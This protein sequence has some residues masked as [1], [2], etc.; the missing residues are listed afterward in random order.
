MKTQPFRFL[1]LPAELRM[2]VYECLSI[3][4]HHHVLDD[5]TQL[6]GYFTRST[7]TLVTKSIETSIFST[8]RKVNA[9]AVPSLAHH[10]DKLRSVPTHFVVDF[11]SM[12]TFAGRGGILSLIKKKARGHNSPTSAQSTAPIVFEGAL[13]VINDIHPTS[14]DY[15]ALTSFIARSTSCL[16]R[17]LSA[18]PVITRAQSLLVTMNLTAENGRIPYSVDKI[19][20][21][22]YMLHELYPCI[23]PH[24]DT[25][26]TWKS[27]KKTRAFLHKLHGTLQSFPRRHDFDC[28]RIDLVSE[29]MWEEEWAEREGS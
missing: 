22:M 17:A 2:M 25:R 28:S 18:T 8:C 6:P 20:L 7:I 23:A 1:D 13:E 10:L 4:V 12:D 24:L 14:A 16:S 5:P 15:I 27:T 9:E 21:K 26:I 3:S 11:A 19:I 29:K